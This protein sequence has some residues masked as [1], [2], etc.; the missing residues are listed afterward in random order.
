MYKHKLLLALLS[1]LFAACTESVDNARQSNDQ[2]RIY[3]DYTGV[4]VP[5]E[6]A[7]L[8][9]NA[10][11]RADEGYEKMD[12]TIN[13]E[14]GG[15]IHTQG[16]VA[17]FDIDEWHQLLAQN[18]GAKLSVKVSM[19]RSGEWT[20]YRP[21]YIYVSNDSLGQWGITYRRIAPG[22]E[23]Y[24]DM[25]LYERDLSNFDEEPILQN[26]QT[27]GQCMNCHVTNRTN[28]DQFVFH[29]RG[30]HGATY[31]HYDGKDEVLQAKNEQIGGSMVYPYWHPTGR[32]CAFSTNQ[33][34]QGFHSLAKERIEVFD[35]S[36]DILVYEPRTHR[37]IQTPLLKT[38]EWSE[39][40]PVFS[41][42]GRWLYF[43]T[44]MQQD[45]P[46]NYKKEQYNLCRIAFDP[47]KGTFGNKVDTL[48]DARS[49]NKSVTWPRP[50]YDGRYML[51]TLQDYGYFSIWHEESDQYLLDLNTGEARRLDEVNSRRADSY[52]NWSANSRWIVFTSRRG[53]GLF[54]HLY[55]AHVGKDG[56]M[57]KP[58]LLPQHNPWK[59]YDASLYSFNTP[60][61][62][63]RP[64]GLDSRKAAANIMSEERV[65]TTT[66]ESK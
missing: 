10:V 23:V 3:P 14:R 5:A 22:Y 46:A 15:E 55:F 16:D 24:S 30:S 44:C 13:G 58:F 53:S 8:N 66:S 32:Y 40:T 54:T 25:G 18:R 6:I 59:Y 65:A 36:S 42:D 47:E 43:T 35:L 29:V 17:Q 62:S 7:P 19:K 31:I 52:H 45:Y 1:F 64:I 37:I 49:K 21:F 57:G 39:N 41:P 51:F 56:K 9:F 50:S 26:T 38:K 60:D 63:Q 61:F 4:T 2:P 12:V 11:A 48:Y 34:R 27:T 33:T 28:P 20:T